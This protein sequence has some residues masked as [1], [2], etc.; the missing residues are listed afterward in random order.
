M[1][2]QWLFRAAL[3]LLIPI[4]GISQST[5]WNSVIDLNVTVDNNARIDLYT[6]KDGN[7]VIVQ[8]SNQL[9]YYFFSATGTQIRTSTRD[10][11]IREDTSLSRMVYEIALPGISAGV[12]GKTFYIPLLFPLRRGI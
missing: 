8:K 10:N 2:K 9:V 5:N 3:L 6:D 11:N 4:W 12:P 1:V 7:H